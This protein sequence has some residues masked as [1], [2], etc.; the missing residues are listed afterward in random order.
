MRNCILVPLDGSEVAETALAMVELIPSQRVLLLQAETPEP[1]ARTRAPGEVA[2]WRERRAREMIDYLDRAAS[3]FRRHG[4]ET[5][6]R[7]V[8]QEP[9]QAIIEAARDAD[10]IVMTTHGRGGAGRAVFGSVADRV[11]REAPVAT[12]LIRSSMGP[13][14]KPPVT[15]IVVPLDGS[16]RSE[17]ALPIALELAND[18][19]VPIQLMQVVEHSPARDAAQAGLPAAVAAASAVERERA[20]AEAYLATIAQDLRNRDTMA[21]GATLTGSPAAALID[22]LRPGDLVVM[23]SRGQGG[24]GRA[25]LGSVAD[26]L[27]H[28]AQAPVLVVRADG[29]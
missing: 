2:S 4:R 14:A 5:E 23:T 22:A 8:W 12:L 6:T 11:A 27:V 29:A 19:G 16:P 21:N 18:L 28:E 17:A 3:R 13:G 1:A 26:R 7:V 15:R 25:L 10:L 24:V 9:A 20:A